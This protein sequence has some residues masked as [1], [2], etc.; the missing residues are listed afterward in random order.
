VLRK[1][2]KQLDDAA[3]RELEQAIHNIFMRYGNDRDKVL[4][5]A[6]NYEK[7]ILYEYFF[8]KAKERFIELLPC[9]GPMVMQVF[10]EHDIYVEYYYNWLNGAFRDDTV[11]ETVELGL[12]FVYERV[13]HGDIVKQFWDEVDP[14]AADTHLSDAT[15]QGMDHMRHKKKHTKN[16][17]FNLA[18]KKLKTDIDYETE[19]IRL[20][21]QWRQEEEAKQKGT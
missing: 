14:D 20:D 6:S 7:N 12:D 4:E 15:R 21:A 8:P 13:V 9:F 3:E 18:V 10:F 11:A 1:K 5:H 16:N 19:T 17:A 2:V